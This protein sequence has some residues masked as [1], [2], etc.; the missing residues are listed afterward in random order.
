[1]NTRLYELPDELIAVIDRL[2]DTYGPD[3]ARAEI[4]RALA[5]REPR[6]S[7]LGDRL[8]LSREPS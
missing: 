6:V 3:A 2:V 5:P 8:A 7:E 4:T 1:M